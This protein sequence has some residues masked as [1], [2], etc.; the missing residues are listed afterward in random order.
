M[1]TE[2]TEKQR[3]WQISVGEE[4]VGVNYSGVC[5]RGRERRR[6]IIFLSFPQKDEELQFSVSAG[7]LI[8]SSSQPQPVS[9]CSY[10]NLSIYNP[11]TRSSSHPSLHHPPNGS[12]HP[13]RV[14]VNTSITLIKLLY[15]FVCFC[16]SIDTF[17]SITS[18]KIPGIITSLPSAPPPD[19]SSLQIHSTLRWNHDQKCLFFLL[20]VSAHFISSWW[21]YTFI[22]PT[23]TSPLSHWFSLSLSL[24]SLLI[25][26]LLFTSCVSLF[27]LWNI[28]R[29][30]KLCLW[31]RAATEQSRVEAGGM[32]LPF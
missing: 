14:F 9:F 27:P 16:V 17:W 18:E 29:M 31:Q 8:F 20:H 5:E 12:I 28:L 1:Y 25:F 32:Y 23:W 13:N 6:K 30:V 15:A 2:A 10:V 22:G 21:F 7:H 11:S 19:K 26:P 24:S 4:V 3:R